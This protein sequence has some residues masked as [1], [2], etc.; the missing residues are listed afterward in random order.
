MAIM[1]GLVLIALTVVCTTV[2]HGHEDATIE[3]LGEEIS[4]VLVGQQLIL[5][6]LF[7]LQDQVKQQKSDRCSCTDKPKGRPNTKLIGLSTLSTT[8]RFYILN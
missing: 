1:S 8:H 4:D 3:E 6:N 7:E 2:I 5:D